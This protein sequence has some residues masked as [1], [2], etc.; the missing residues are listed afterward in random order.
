M[1]R[2]ALAFTAIT[3]LP[4]PLLALGATLGGPWAWIALGYL[5]LFAFA[6]DELAAAT[7]ADVAPDREFPA[8]DGLAVALALAH[9]ALLGLVVCAIGRGWVTGAGEVTAL[10]L[11]AGLF[12]GQVSNSNAH[13]LIHRRSKGLFQ[14]GKWVF[15]SLLFG[16]HASAHP[17][18]HHRHVGTDRDPNSARLG[19]SY[20]RFALRAWRGSFLAGYRA[21]TAR[22]AGRGGA[23]PYAE[24]VLGALAVMALATLAAGLRGLAVLIALALFAQSQLLL[25]DYV[26][27][28][29]L[30]RQ[31]GPDGRP[32]PVAPR[33]SWNAPHWFTRHMMLNAPRHSDHHAHPARPFPELTLPADG[34]LPMLPRSLPAMSILALVP[35]LWRRAMD[36]RA[37]AWA[38]AG[39]G[40]RAA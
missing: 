25:S 26:Q 33:H 21:E 16:H 3:L 11:A 29:G 35:P 15:I 32:E 4:V 17:Q 1:P 13:E 40:R 18:V 34:T 6:L 27:H 24:Y 19:Q 31:T 36:P 5:T 2:P 8:A 10:M 28:Y 9:F 20:Y 14:L 23:H 39:A 38:A 7:A 37:R 12:F 22:R 30:R